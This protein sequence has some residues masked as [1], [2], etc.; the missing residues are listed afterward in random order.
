M[1]A[2]ANEVTREYLGINTAHST[3]HSTETF[4]KDSM[5]ISRKYWNI[6]ERLQNVAGML[7]QASSN[8]KMSAL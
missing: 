5:N 7:L 3:E 2:L 4:Q 8:V 1:A 6:A